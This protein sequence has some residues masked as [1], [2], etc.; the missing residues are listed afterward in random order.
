MTATT[1]RETKRV[2]VG[3]AD[4]FQ[5]PHGGYRV[6]ARFGGQVSGNEY[7]YEGRAARAPGRSGF[8][9]NAYTVDIASPYRR[10]V[11]R[12][13]LLSTVRHFAN[14]GL[15]AVANDVDDRRHAATFVLYVD[16]DDDPKEEV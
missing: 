15:V 11:W 16:V 4:L 9:L 14:R 7:G 1:K 10:N 8:D 12:D 2:L 13:V 6:A 3:W 5:S